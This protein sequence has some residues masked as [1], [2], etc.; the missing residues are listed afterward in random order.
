VTT[1]KLKYVRRKGGKLFWEPNRAMRDL[2]FMPKPL[3]D[4]GPAAHAE[5]LKLYQS[6]VRASADRGKVT[7]YP[8]GTFG[9]YWDRLRGSKD[10]PGLWWKSKSLR[11]REDYARAWPLI[12]K[13]RPEPDKPT[14][15]RTVITAI[16]TET[17]EAFFE[18]LADSQSPSMR[19]RTFKVLKIL[20]ADCVARLRLGYASPASKIQNPQPAGRSA[21]WLGAE[22]PILV[23]A[24]E[25]MGYGGMAVAIRIGW[26]TLFSPVDVR[27][28]TARMRKNDG[29]G[30]YLHRDRTKTSKEA[31]GAL[32]EATTAALNA[33]LAAMGCELLPDTPLIRQR[34]GNA[35]RSK[36][37]FGDDFRAVRS[38]AFPGD[39]RQFLDIRR[40][41][42]VEA[43][44]ADVDKATMGQILA[45]SLAD[46]RFIDDTYTPPTVA[47]ARE[48]V[49]KRAAGRQALAGEVMR[50]RNSNSAS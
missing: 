2:G 19:W 47:K 16:T 32:S 23:R 15:S 7:S 28:V 11:G 17:C 3:G 45:N 49:S 26:D 31:F 34:D 48:I 40:S 27:T 36:D 8:P 18:H 37:T 44:V 43:D 35:Y 50:V 41:G 14:L 46:N 33:H 4:D 21:I 13:W 39:A 12:D 9:A 1:V 20:L 25:D 6:W 38:K 24:A 22:I 10:K 30:D 42:N 29:Q 5:A